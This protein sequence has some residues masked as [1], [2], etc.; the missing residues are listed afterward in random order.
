MTL[1]DK[2]RML[3]ENNFKPFENTDIQKIL[4]E[5]LKQLGSTDSELRDDL[6]YG[7]ISNWI[8]EGF[9]TESELKHLQETLISDDFLFYQIGEQGTDSIFR[10]SF[11]VLLL[12]PIIYIHHKKNIFST[13]EVR[14][15][16]NKTID[17]L[18]LEKD[19]RGNV[20]KKGWAH[21]IAH[22]ADSLYQLIEYLD[23]KDITR[24]L[25]SIAL[26]FST[27]DY[28]LKDEEDERTVNFLVKSIMKGK[29]RIQDFNAWLS[30]LSKVD[31][32]LNYEK[33][34][35]IKSNIKSLIRSL[36]LRLNYLNKEE[37]TIYLV[38]IDKALEGLDLHY[39]QISMDDY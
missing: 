9:L 36:Y 23:E 18:T 22:T 27:H 19:L 12:A 24:V 17:Y 37:F 31:S 14:V 25:K 5:S 16:I 2:L 21:S 39:Y 34:Y 4:Q 6:I 26:K 10:R 30:K 15:I 20:S 33:L 32:N 3:K 29:V 11:S 35:T 1:K 38:S 7:T 28:I 8:V 13:E